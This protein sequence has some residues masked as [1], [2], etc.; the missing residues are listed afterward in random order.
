MTSKGAKL[1]NFKKP[2]FSGIF[3][4]L[5]ERGNNVEDYKTWIKLTLYNG[6]V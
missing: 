2:Y 4:V 5:K 6:I 1:L 3:A